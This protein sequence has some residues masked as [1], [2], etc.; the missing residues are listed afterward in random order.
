MIIV[1][2][3][4]MVKTSFK[5]SRLPLVFRNEHLFQR[6]NLIQDET[7][8]PLESEIRKLKRHSTS[9]K[10]GKGE[11]TNLMPRNSPKQSRDSQTLSCDY[12]LIFFLQSKTT[13]AF[14]MQIN[15]TGVTS[16]TQD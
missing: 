15:S 16:I 8:I 3:R 14:L 4:L 10:K 11:C 7:Q 5:L 1:Q 6:R 13:P 9:V 12:P 2:S